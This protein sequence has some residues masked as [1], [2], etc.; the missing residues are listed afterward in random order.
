MN[1]KDADLKPAYFPAYKVELFERQISQRAGGVMLYYKVFFYL[2][3]YQQQRLSG[4]LVRSL[5]ISSHR[6]ATQ[7]HEAHR[8]VTGS[9]RVAAAV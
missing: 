3:I 9:A 4:K 8:K 7:S 1:D 2:S 6:Y 5:R